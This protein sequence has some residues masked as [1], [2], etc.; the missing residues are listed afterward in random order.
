M[1]YD[2]KV[3]QATSSKKNIKESIKINIPLNDSTDI[4]E[5]KLKEI[6]D[7]QIRQS[8][9][10]FAFY[11]SKPKDYLTEMTRSGSENELSKKISAAMKKF[12]ESHFKTSSVELKSLLQETNDKYLSFGINFYLAYSPL[13]SE[14]YYAAIKLFIESASDSSPENTFMNDSQWFL[15]LTYV[16]MVEF[17]KAVKYFEQ[18]QG[19]QWSI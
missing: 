18:N 2:N 10:L 16:K 14:E 3:K 5:K 6:R 13:K 17:D 1:N 12:N 7:S 4:D 9:K 15:S 19:K 11:D 8:E